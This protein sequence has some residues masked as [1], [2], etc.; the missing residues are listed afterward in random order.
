M[1]AAIVTGPHDTETP[2]N[3]LWKMQVT[4]TKPIVI[5]V[6]KLTQPK[7]PA[8]TVFARVESTQRLARDRIAVEHEFEIDILNGTVPE[9][10]LD[11]SGSLQPYHVSLVGGEVTNWKWQEI[12]GKKEPKGKQSPARGVLTIQFAQPVRGKIKSLHVKNS[13][14]RIE[15]GVW[16]SPALHVRDA[17]SRGE[18]LQIRLPSEVPVGRWDHGS[19]Q[20]TNMTTGKTA[21]K[22]LPSQRRRE[23]SRPPGVQP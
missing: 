22:S 20:P 23:T 19:F 9:L 8:P 16:T 21:C 7:G 18:T 4:C 14:P 5:S 6:Q 15:A 12:A 17:V 2:A 10:I 11:G 1:G 3:R 13:C